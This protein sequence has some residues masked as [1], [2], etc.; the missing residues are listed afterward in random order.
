MENTEDVQSA[1]KDRPV[2][3]PVSLQRDLGFSDADILRVLLQV[4]AQQGQILA[5]LLEFGFL[6][7]DLT[8]AV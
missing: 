6:L 4:V 2:F 8:V 3:I 5:D 7:G 1:P